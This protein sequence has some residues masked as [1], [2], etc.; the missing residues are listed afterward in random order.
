MGTSTTRQEAVESIKQGLGEGVVNSIPLPTAGGMQ[1]ILIVA[2][3]AATYLVSRS[4]TEQ[5]RKLNR[6]IHMEVLPALRKTGTYTVPS[7]NDQPLTTYKLALEVANLMGFTGNQALLSADNYIKASYGVSVVEK[8]HPTGL[9][10]Q[11]KE[12]TY[13]P[14]ELGKMNDPPLSAMKFNHL[15][16]AF[17]LQTHNGHGYDPTEAGLQHCEVLDTQKRHS[18][19]TPIK[20]IKWFKSV[21]DLL[22]E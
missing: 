5:G 13:T 7:T 2:E 6:F 21:L 18:D 15:L 22:V 11:R 17:G 12:L 16:A 4:N 20:Q 8:M 19:G 1:Q 3:S 9:I 14:T 10:A